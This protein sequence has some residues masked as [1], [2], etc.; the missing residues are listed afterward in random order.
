MNSTDKSSFSPNKDRNAPSTLEKDIQNWVNQKQK[1]FCKSARL[2]N[3][4]IRA[5]GQLGR[6]EEAVSVLRDMEEIKLKP[7][8]MV[9]MAHPFVKQRNH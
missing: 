9:Q 3:K 6:W 7:N 1:G 4:A 2:P 5:Y 8:V